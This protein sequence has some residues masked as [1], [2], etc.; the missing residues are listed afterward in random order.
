MNLSESLH[1]ILQQDQTMA[2]LFYLVFLDR[3][4]EVRKHFRKVDLKRQAVLLTTILMV[5]ERH[6]AHTYPVTTDFLR[7]LGTKHYLWGIAPDLFPKFRSALLLT[8]ERF[9]AN[10]W[11]PG[12]ALQWSECLDR[13]IEVMLSGYPKPDAPRQ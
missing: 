11:T 2:D 12:L 7:Q 10:D 5:L 4:P 3:Y 1:R 8:L 9:H 6:Q 13:A